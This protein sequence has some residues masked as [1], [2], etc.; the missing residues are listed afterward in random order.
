[1]N[2]ITNSSGQVP[3]IPGLHGL[4]DTATPKEAYERTGLD[5]EDYKLVFS[6][7]FNHDGR[8]FWPGDDPFVP[9]L[10][11][12][13]RCTRSQRPLSDRYWEAVDLHYVRLSSP[14]SKRN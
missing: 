1:M 6:D 13:V 8:T 14:A 7:E 9:L 3:A 4:I 2:T 11:S 10:R 12:L 5:G